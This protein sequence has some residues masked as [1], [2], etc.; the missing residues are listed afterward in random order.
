[1]I[2]KENLSTTTVSGI[3]SFKSGGKLN[4]KSDALMH[5]KSG[6]IID[7]DATNLLG[8]GEVDIDADII[9]LN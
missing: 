5:I 1:M 7:I 3:T 9:N 4:M 2:A 6:T 8:F